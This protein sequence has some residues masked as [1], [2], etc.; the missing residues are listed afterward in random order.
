MKQLSFS[1]LNN[2]AIP[3]LL[4]ITLSGCRPSKEER[5]SSADFKNLTSKN[6]SSNKRAMGSIASIVPYGKRDYYW[7]KEQAIQ[8]VSNLFGYPAEQENYDDCWCQVLWDGLD[9][10]K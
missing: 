3:F 10:K 5:V 7:V 1:V 2:L 9:I 4:T 6:W 8:S